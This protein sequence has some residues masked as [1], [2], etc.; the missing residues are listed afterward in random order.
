M[1]NTQKAEKIMSLIAAK[2]DIDAE[3]IKPESTWSEIGLDSLDVVEL[4]MEVENEFHISIPD[5]ESHDF[6]TV[7]HVIK[8]ME[9]HG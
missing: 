8:Y 1:E 4:L 9:T 7:G 6:I 5:D 2:A 3:E